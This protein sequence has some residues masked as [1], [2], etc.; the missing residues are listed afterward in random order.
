MAHSDCGWTCGCAG[1]TVKSLENTCHTWALLRWWFTKSCYIKCTYL[2]LY[3]LPSPKKNLCWLRCKIMYMLESIPVT[4]STGSEQWRNN[5]TNNTKQ[6]RIEFY[7]P[8]RI[9]FLQYDNRPHITTSCFHWNTYTTFCGLQATGHFGLTR[10]THTT[11]TVTRWL[12]T[13]Y[14]D[15]NNNN[16]NNN[17]NNTSLMATDYYY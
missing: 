11:I 2:Y 17:Q 4:R 12:L 3:R 1:K 13:L 9:Q 6:Y 15:I 16:N 14:C 7:S 10:N 5:H 8:R